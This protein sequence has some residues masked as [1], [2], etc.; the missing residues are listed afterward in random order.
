MLHTPAQRIV[1]LK[2]SII[3]Y[4][5]LPTTVNVV[6]NWITLILSLINDLHT[7]IFAF[8]ARDFLF[9]LRD[10]FSLLNKLTNIQ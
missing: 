3:L 2:F 10:P 4:Y 1:K 6:H 9:L 7:T 5:V 8:H